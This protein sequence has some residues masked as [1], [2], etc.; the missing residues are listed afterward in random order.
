MAASKQLFQ[1]MFCLKDLPEFEKANTFKC[2]QPIVNKTSVIAKKMISNMKTG[3]W[4]GGDNAEENR[5]DE[6]I[7]RR[8]KRDTEDEDTFE[9]I[10][11]FAL[12]SGNSGTENDDS[13]VTA[14]QL[15]LDK[16]K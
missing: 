11:F 7:I 13:S 15:L 16:Q 8:K 3:K 10:P 5:N 4:K 1:S 12:L 9:S 2:L 14:F 6:K